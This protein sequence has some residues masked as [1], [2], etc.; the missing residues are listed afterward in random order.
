VTLDLISLIGLATTSVGLWT[1]RVA[2]TANGSKLAAAAIAAVEATVFVIAFSRVAHGLGSPIPLA[3]YAFGVGLGTLVGLDLHT[4]LGRG[5]AQV[6]VVAQRPSGCLVDGLCNAGWPATAIAGH[7]VSGPVEVL[8]VTVD[9]QCLADLLADL[10]NLVPR[11]PLDRHTPPLGTT[12][13]RFTPNRTTTANH[14]HVTTARS[15]PVTDT[16]ENLT[17]EQPRTSPSQPTSTRSS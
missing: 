13:Q 4:R 16:F 10:G 17:T 3:A 9:D 6:Q 8:S 5:Q 14:V 12:P 11:R 15:P 7:G 1:V 2:V